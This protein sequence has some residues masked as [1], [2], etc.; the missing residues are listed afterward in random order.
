MSP[1]ALSRQLGIETPAAFDYTNSETFGLYVAS[2][3][4]YNALLS[5]RG[6]PQVSLGRDGYLITCDM[7]ETASDLYDH[8]MSEGKTLAIAGHD[9]RPVASK[10]DVK[11]GALGNSAMGCN[12]G[13]VIVPDAVLARPNYTLAFSTLLANYRQDVT[14]KQGDDFFHGLVLTTLGERDAATCH[15]ATGADHRPPQRD[16][17]AVQ[18]DARLHGYLAIYIGFVLVVA[19]AA[20]LT[21]QQLSGM[22]DSTRSY[23]V[24]SELGCETSEIR[25]SMLAQQAVFFVFPLVVGVAHSSVALHVIIDLVKVMGNISIGGTVGLT[26]AVFLAAYGGYFVLTYVMGTGIVRDAIRV[27]KSE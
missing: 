23:R 21:I 3:S 10:V 15:A 2:E 19:C 24:L 13:T 17:R 12:P 14:T 6:L 1:S 16:V 7:G 18:L 22:A 4:Q 5:L 8:F 26:C 25:H 9:L 20:I 11:A 27:R